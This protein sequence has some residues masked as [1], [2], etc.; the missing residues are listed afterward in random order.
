MPKITNFTSQVKNKDRVNVFIDE[1][2]TFSLD[3]F[4]VSELGLKIG[5]E[6]SESDLENLK[7]ASDFGKLYTKTINWLV[8]RPHSERETRDYLFKKSAS[9]E[10]TNAIISRLKTKNYLNDATFTRFWI[11]NRF[12]K[13]GISK[14][15]LEVELLKKGIT[16]ETITEAL[17]N[18]PRNEAEEIDK[19]I[20]KKRQKYANE[21]NKLLA[22]LIRQ[23]FD[24][25][26]ARS[27]VFGTDS[28]SSE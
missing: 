18:S 3:I 27:R 11:E 17:K 12:Q 10:L 14:K 6:L 24:Y 20:I 28:Q 15:R 5:A 2:Y 1:K 19:I 23:G 8:S 16:K 22:Y 13:K 25:E 4:Q 21:P 9:P 7:K 26:L